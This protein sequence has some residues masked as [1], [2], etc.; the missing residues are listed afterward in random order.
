MNAG[1]TF[2]RVMDI[3]F[4]GEWDKFVVIYLDDV[5]FFS[6]LDEDHM[7]HLKQTF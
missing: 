7:I 4:V 5:T 2:Q 1:A 3:S 6:K